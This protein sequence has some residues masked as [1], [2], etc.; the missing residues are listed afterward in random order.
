VEQQL[1]RRFGTSR[2]PL[3]EAL[4]LLGQQGLVE[5]LPRRGVRVVRLSSRD[6]GELFDLRDVLEQFA[7]RQALGGSR[8]PSWRGTAPARSSGRS[9]VPPA[10]DRTRDTAVT[11]GLSTCHRSV[12]NRHQ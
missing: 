10:R 7:L 9:W 3:R 5:H 1:T 2:A 12:D 8:P 4:R 11:E 6:I